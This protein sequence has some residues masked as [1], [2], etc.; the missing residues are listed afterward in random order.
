MEVFVIL[1]FLVISL[2]RNTEADKIREEVELKRL[3]VASEKAQEAAKVLSGQLDA[4]ARERDSWKAKYISDYPSDCK[5]SGVP[6]V[7][8]DAC[9]VAKDQISVRMLGTLASH[10]IGEVGVYSSESFRRSFTDIW[11]ISYARAC[12]FTAV[13]RHNGGVETDDYVA[14]NQAISSRFRIEWV[15]ERC[16]R[17]SSE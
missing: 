1:C 17:T 3:T 9:I 14:G 15:A 2:L 5:M 7:L 10:H 13:V 8:I 11:D 16:F 6:R 12:R 4:A